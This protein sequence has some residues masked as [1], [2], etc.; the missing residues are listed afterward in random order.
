MM[1]AR[2]EAAHVEQ[3]P[4]IVVVSGSGATADVLGTEITK[5]FDDDY[6]VVICREIAHARR[7]LEELSARNA[8][9]ALVLA[10]YARNDPEGLSVLRETRRWHPAAKRAAVVTWGEFDLADDVFVAL[11]EGSIDGYL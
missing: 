9:V 10:G 3:P 4:V 7:D 6:E 5:R 8:D 1:A 2:R 11:G